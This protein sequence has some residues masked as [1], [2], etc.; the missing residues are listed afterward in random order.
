MFLFGWVGE[1][2]R[3]GGDLWSLLGGFSSV[4]SRVQWKRV[5][6]VDAI[7]L[8]VRWIGPA[9]D[10]VGLKACVVAS[11]RWASTTPSRET[12][13]LAVDESIRPYP[14]HY[15]HAHTSHPPTHPT[16]WHHVHTRA[17]PVS[18]I[19]RTP[20]H[21]QVYAQP[22][23]YWRGA[24]GLQQGR[25]TGGPGGITVPGGDGLSLW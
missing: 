15:H 20:T 19:W 6:E 16:D 3:G 22:P 8:W 2:G 7:G 17:R 13:L 21:S 14:S 12:S 23:G 10:D 24:C 1:L 25:R 18:L 5:W 4:S 11:L 9:A